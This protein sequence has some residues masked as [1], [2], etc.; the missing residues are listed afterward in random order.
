VQF[1]ADETDTVATNL[2]FNAQ[3]ADSAPTFDS[4]TNN[5]S[6]RPVTT[7]SASWSPAPW[8]TVGEAGAAQ[9]TSDI[10]AVIQAVVDRPGWASGNSLVLVVTGSG[11]RVAESYNG[12][13]AGAPLLELEYAVPNQQRPQVDAGA[14]ATVSIPDTVA[15]DGTVTDDGLPNPPGA[16]TTTWSKVSGPGTVTFGDASAVDTTAAFSDPGSYVLRLTADDGELSANDTLTVTAVGAGNQIVESR[17]AA[18][19]D[20]AEE[21]AGGVGIGSSDLELVEESSTQTV[22]MRFTG[23]A[24][25]PGATIVDATVQFQADETDTVATNLTFQAQAADNPPTFQNLP[26]NITSRPV[27]TASAAWSPAPWN[28]VGAA[29]PDQKTSDISAVIQEIVDRPGW[30]SGN[31]LVLIVTGS[32]KRVAE[33]YNGDAAGAP[34]LQVTYTV[35]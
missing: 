31:A 13:S 7:A 35:N 10:A 15:L 29:G 2:T 19:T 24:V 11:K 6:S 25:P 14:D 20:D 21:D 32:G 4:T 33:S 30:A 23:L 34:L 3:A 26:G 27:T 12:D 9:K 22:G 8:N 28:T 16:V 18:S 5:I 17:V 1:K